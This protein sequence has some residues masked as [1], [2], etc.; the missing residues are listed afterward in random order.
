MKK[1]PQIRLGGIT[2]TSLDGRRF[3]LQDPH[4]P[5]C[6]VTLEDADVAD[7]IVWLQEHSRKA[8]KEIKVYRV[9]YKGTA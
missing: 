7:L 2:V 6:A 9:S 1:Q 4:K 5:E 8:A 3:V